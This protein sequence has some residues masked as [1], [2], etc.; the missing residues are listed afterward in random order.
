[1]I[2]DFSQVMIANLKAQIGNHTNMEV[3]EGLLRHMILNTLRALN[4]KFKD[5]Y[6]ELVIACDDRHYW[7]RDIFPYYKANRKKDRENSELNWV[8]IFE[9]LHRIRDEIKEHFPYKVIQVDGAE[10]D[11]VI[12]C[13]IHE[14][15][16]RPLGGEPVLILSGDKDYRQ[17]QVYPNVTQ[18]DPVKKKWLREND[19]Q[20][21]LKEHIMRGDKGDGVPNFLSADNSYVVG[22][23]QTSIYQVKIDEWLKQKPED[24][25]DEL[26][27]KRYKRNENLVDLS[28][29]PESVKEKI[30]N[31]YDGA[32]SGDR[33]KLFNYFITHSL[34]NLIQSIGDF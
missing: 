1:M 24:F 30:L 21:Y 22:T 20:G 14:R 9:S 25:C 15:F 3:D 23:R 6:G 27:L 29:I 8:A 13:L 32:N 33:S 17:L 19:P 34:R 10:A 28:K 16:G 7:R 18:Y 5:E 31:T 4:M 2:V 26:M 11:D 12:G